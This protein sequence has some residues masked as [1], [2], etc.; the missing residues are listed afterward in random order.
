[1][2]PIRSLHARYEQVMS[3]IPNVSYMYPDC[4]LMQTQDTIRI[5]RPIGYIL[6]YSIPQ[7]TV[8]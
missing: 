7:D 3:R 6:G 2:Y 4:I 8:S 5:Q 1:M